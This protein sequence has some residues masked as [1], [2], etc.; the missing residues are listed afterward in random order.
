MILSSSPS[1][2][3][4]NRSDLINNILNPN[5]YDAERLNTIKKLTSSTIEGIE[6]KPLSDI[7]SF[8]T[9]SR[10]YEHVTEETKHISVLHIN[11]DSTIDFKQVYDYAPIC[12]GRKCYSGDILFSKINPRIPRMT[13]IPKD[14]EKKLVCS[15]EFEIMKPKTDI[16]AYTICFLLKTSYVMNQIENLTSGTSSSSKIL[17]ILFELF[18]LLSCVFPPK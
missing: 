18:A 15:N 3:L 11:S 9:V 8:E 12:K 10:N 4:I 7:V 1:A 17:S 13:V 2:T 6:F 14:I 5:F 16:G